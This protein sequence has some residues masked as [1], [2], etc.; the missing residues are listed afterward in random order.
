MALYPRLDLRP[1]QNL[2]LTPQLRQAIKLLELSNLELTDYLQQAALDNPFLTLEEPESDTPV[3]SEPSE[4]THDT[5]DISDLKSEDYDNLWSGESEETS[6]KDTNARD[7]RWGD[8]FAGFASIES[9]PLTLR[10]HLLSQLNTD[11]TDFREKLVGRYL[12]E[13]VDETGY[14]TLDLKETALRF[15]CSR[16]FLEEVLKKLQ[17]FDPSG[18]CA[19]SLEECLRL[20]LS[21]KGKLDSSMEK[22]LSNLDLLARGKLE[23]LTKIVGCDLETLRA[24]IYELRSLDPKPGLKFERSTIAPLI[25]DVFVR[26][27]IETGEWRVALNQA[28]LPRLL[29]DQDYTFTL[30]KGEADKKTKRYLQERFSSANW[31]IR[32]LDQ[33]AR[34]IL[35]VSIEIVKHQQKF[36]EQGIVGLRPLALKDIA[37]AVAMH[38]STISRVTSHKYVG[39][40]R[41]VFE[42]KY[43]F[44]NALSGII[45]GAE[46]AT[47]AVRHRIKEMVDAENK[48][49]PLSDDQIVEKLEIEGIHVARRTIAKYREAL[50]IPSSYQRR[51]DHLKAA[52]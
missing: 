2:T 36:F 20:Q 32:A 21:D 25:P 51:R 34:T 23:K 9:E 48:E 3:S 43:F 29:I 27:N 7:G 26:K 6:W 35:N 31:L 44:T 11:L 50:G 24:K 12:I 49:K 19:R 52:S 37:L 45:E 47:E 1:E 42:L 33:R 22:L 46:F 5:G 39:T 8:D 30:K 18:V 4:I 17:R 16:A 15:G 13:S 10:E 28:T 40:P 41:G 38:E 14:L